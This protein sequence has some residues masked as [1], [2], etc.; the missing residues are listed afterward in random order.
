[1]PVD[2]ANRAASLQTLTSVLPDLATNIMN[3]YSRAWTFTDDKLPPLAFAQSAIR[4]AKLLSSIQ[5]SNGVLDDAL[6][7]HLVLN[8]EQPTNESSSSD[9]PPFMTR[10]EIVDLVFRAYPGPNAEPSMTVSDRTTIF[11]GIAAVLSD[12]K[13]HRKK[14][15]VLKDLMSSLLPAL[16]Q[17]RKAGAAEM[18]VHP[19]ASLASLNAAVNTVALKSSVITSD[20][21]EQGMKHFLSLVCQAYGIVPFHSIDDDKV[22]PTASN[23][24]KTRTSSPAVGGAYAEAVASRALQQASSKMSGSQDLKID[25][26]RSCINICEALPDLSGALH[27]SAELLR[28]GASGIA[29]GPDSSDGS[30]DLAIDEQVRLVNNISRTLSAARQ[31]GFE[32][33]EAEYWDDFLVRG[34]EV[35]DVNPARSL[36][37]H[38][39]SELEIVETIDAKK[40]K[41][42]FIYNPFLKSNAAPAAE[43]L[44]VAR[45]EAFFRVTLQNLSDFDV[46]VERIKVVSHG[47][48]LESV[49]QSILIGPYRTQTT[50]LSGTPQL[51]GRLTIHGCSVKIKG[52]RERSFLHF[53]E[54]WS[55]KVDVKNRHVHLA[56]RPRPAAILVESGKGKPQQSFKGPIPTTL[57]LNVLGAQPNIAMKSISIPQLAIMLLEG[58]TANFT[59]TLSNTSWIDPVDLLLLSFDDS[60]ASQR[61]SA[62]SNKELSAVELYE[63]ELASARKQ[64]LRWRSRH[65]IQID[66]GSVA[67]LDLEVLG[68][69]GLSHGTIQVDYCHLG[70]PRAQIQDTFYTRQLMIPLTI[71]VNPSLDIVSSDI[72]NLPKIYSTSDLPQRE[73]DTTTLDDLNQRPHSI[74]ADDKTTKPDNSRLNIEPLLNRIRL[75]SASTPYCLL[76]L[77][78]HNS[79]TNTL[80]LSLE[81]SPPSP[82][83]HPFTHT[84]PLHANTTTRIPIPLSRLYMPNPHQPIPSLNPSTKRQFVVSTTK[85]NP[86]AERALRE[87]FWYREEL[88]SQLK[89]SWKEEST[90]RIGDVDLRTIKLTSEMIAALKLLDLDIGMTISSAEPS[91]EVHQTTAS[92]FKVP[93]TTFLTLH[94]HLYN[95]SSD[96][97]RPLLRLQPALANQPQSIALDLNKKLL[98][99][100]I[101]QRALPELGPGERSTVETGFMVLA[102]GRYE[103]GAVVEEVVAL[104]RDEGGGKRVGGRARAAT[105]EMDVLGERGRRMWVMEGRCGVVATDEEG[106]GDEAEDN[107][108]NS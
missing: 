84:Q 13:Y 100:G 90:G 5:L 51:A 72:I 47:A 66:P 65:D 69:S 98:V 79:W 63:L 73:G 25:I 68:K 70:I 4:F 45:E 61:Q 56:K 75:S 58:E 38:S 86:S 81:L 52:C 8:L 71:T 18:G 82:T 6:L 12:L 48:T 96:P 7:G 57:S 34:I 94:T 40:E 95:R 43:P 60:L 85:S 31:L 22:E 49:Y 101:L 19:A 14:A 37:P 93:T 46:E 41:S 103:W 76:L 30:P 16:V 50:L 102:G 74:T 88:L 108:D 67:T 17:A 105:G 27:Y 97:I 33:Q 3:L 36:Q 53:N 9:V 78:I 59:I 2:S 87:N 29:P 39:K 32:N 11:A 64:T 21:S 44:L 54:P 91:S 83:S 24:K 42:P 62:I 35:V 28:L 99:N 104:G 1:M 77:D 20:G 23:G 92:D 26:L 89:A 10:G 15:L 55:L 106:D 80:I 107:P